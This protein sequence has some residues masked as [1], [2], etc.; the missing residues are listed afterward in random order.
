MNLRW[1][2]AF[3]SAILPV[4][5]SEVPATALD[6]VRRAGTRPRADC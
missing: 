1:S 6:L 5:F 4:L 3:K 2:V